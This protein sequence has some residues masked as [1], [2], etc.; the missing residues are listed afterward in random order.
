MEILNIK[1]YIHKDLIN[2]YHYI[3]NILS[4]NL[5]ILQSN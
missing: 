3:P 4:C 5:Y 1:Q 2:K